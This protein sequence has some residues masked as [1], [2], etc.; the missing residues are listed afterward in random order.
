MTKSRSFLQALNPFK[1]RSRRGGEEDVETVASQEQKQFTLHTLVVATKDFHPSNKLG[2]GG[3]GPV[4]KGKLD[5][6]R[7]IAVKKLSQS[8][9]QGKREF[10]NEAKL[11]ARVQH[12]NVVT[13][14]GYCAH[15]VEKLLVYEY[16]ANESLYKLLFKSGRRE[17]FDWK[18]RYDT[19]TGVA[20]G[21]LYLHED[22]HTCIIH[23][24]IKAS[25]ILLD[26]KWRAKIADFGMARLYPEDKTH[27]NTRVAGTTGYMAPEYVM[28]G[29]LSIKAD[30]YSFGV[31]L[32][33]IISGQKNSS[34]NLDPDSQSLLDWA[35]KLYKLDR[36]LEVVD[37]ALASTVVPAHAELCIKV[38]LLCTQSDPHLRPTMRRVVVVLSQKPVTLEEPTKPGYVGATYR[39]NRRHNASSS[40]ARANSSSQSFGS[41]TNSNTASLSATA[42]TSGTA[43]ATV[44]E[45][46]RKSALT[47][48]SR[49]A[50]PRGK[51]PVED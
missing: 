14:L 34:F 46:A 15:G 37:A 10:L 32:L 40:T 16:V 51:R 28:N 7:L 50:D 21:L 33:E 1:S 25:N 9:S 12:R 17:E 41:L 24:D 36:T 47:D 4:F 27:V 19:I 20:Q 11:L 31:L 35:Y 3:F 43:T 8:S 44:T 42:T 30:V 13:L 45:A 38:G 26:D 39:R 5:D 48:S 23:R 49:V 22:A 2:Q 18:K 29:N 6:G